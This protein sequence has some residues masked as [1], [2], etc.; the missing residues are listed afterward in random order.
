MPKFN[1][2]WTKHTDKVLHFAAGFVICLV[3]YGISTRIFAPYLYWWMA[4]LA[5]FI[6]AVGK[7]TRDMLKANNAGVFDFLDIGATQSGGIV[8]MFTLMFLQRI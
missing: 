3:A 4:Q 6:V 7:E 8:A 5:V 1:S 2:F